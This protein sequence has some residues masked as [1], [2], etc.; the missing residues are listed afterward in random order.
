MQ[1]HFKERR[2]FTTLSSYL[3]YLRFL[4]SYL[5]RSCEEHSV[6][7]ISDMMRDNILIHHRIHNSGYPVTLTKMCAG[8]PKTF[9]A[10]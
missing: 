4:S 3:R 2:L 10:P 6:L 7:Y 9:L 1:F 5:F 8:I